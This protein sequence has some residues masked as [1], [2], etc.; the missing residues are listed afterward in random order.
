MKPQ[1]ST[2]NPTTEPEPSAS[3]L[4]EHLQWEWAARQGLIDSVGGAAWR[5]RHRGTRF[6]TPRWLEAHAHVVEAIDGG[7][8]PSAEL[9]T[10]LVTA[11][12]ASRRH[13]CGGGLRADDPG[14]REEV[15]R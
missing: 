8:R 10:A 3:A 1:N 2:T 12:V 11:V 15:P 5:R 4:I 9:T 6:V 13:A 14:V 7:R